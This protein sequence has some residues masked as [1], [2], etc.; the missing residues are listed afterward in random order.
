MNAAIIV[1]AGQGIR[2]GGSI[3]KQYLPLD[4]EPILGHTLRLFTESRLFEDILL[5][6]PGAD[7]DYCRETLLAALGAPPAVRLVIGGAERQ[8]SVYNGLAACRGGDD[9]VVLIHDGVR[10]FVSIALL[11]QC[12]DS[13]QRNGACVLAV[14]ASD[15]LKQAGPDGAIVQTLPRD[16]VWLAQTPQ[17]FRL[18]LIREA[19]QRAR[20]A[21]YAGTDD[22]Q[23]VE[24]LGH[25]VAIV[26]GSRLNIKIT[27]PDDLHLAE[28]LWRHGR[29]VGGR[30][31]PLA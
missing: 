26:P 12:L 3:R 14:R 9:A 2:M 1:A 22:A 11:R 13:A 21:G 27:T 5:V 29:R 4:G 28:A 7:A 30:G 17:G 10:P 31:L 24:R 23:L 20:E 6:V 19:H 18:A 15:T 16:D 25:P 8:E